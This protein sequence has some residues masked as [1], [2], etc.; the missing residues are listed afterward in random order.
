MDS[1]SDL[2]SSFSEDSVDDLL[3]RYNANQALGEDEEENE[4]LFDL[5]VGDEDD[6]DDED[7]EEGAAGD[8][9]EDEAVDDEF[10]QDSP[11]QKYEIQAQKEEMA[12]D[13]EDENADEEDGLP[14]A[15]AWGSQKKDYY[16]TDYVD[17]NK[18]KFDH[19]LDDEAKAEEEEAL[20]IQK[21]LMK[22]MDNVDL[23]LNNELLEDDE[24]EENDDELDEEEEKESKVQVNVEGLSEREKNQLLSRLHPELVPLLD[25]LRMC[26]ESNAKIEPLITFA[27]TRKGQNLL[28]HPAYHAMK[29][30]YRVR[31]RYMANL[32]V[33]LALK[34]EGEDIRKHAISS[35]LL[36][37]KRLVKEAEEAVKKHKLDKC[38]LDLASRLSKGKEEEEEEAVEEEEKELQVAPGSLSHTR[39]VQELHLDRQL[40]QRVESQK[41]LLAVASASTSTS[42]G[43]RRNITYEMAKNKGLTAQKKKELRNPRVKH[44]MKYDKAK[45]R[46][47]GQVREPRK[48]LSKY[49]GEATGI[50]SGLVRSIKF[51]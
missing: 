47:K 28:D 16:D 20:D 30:L 10:D 25:D 24:E 49:S 37:Y 34:G 22:E 45:K 11:L 27:N 1:D 35:R 21:R 18:R 32:A 42:Q 17:T 3:T 12:S 39:L 26:S 8:F 4:P 43:D 14:D 33:Y 50:K 48:E 19:G 13:I 41:N 2:E 40:S 46:R 15:T 51:K 38:S 9:E 6:D 29:L 7:D 44:R 5:N 23:G 36:S 31:R